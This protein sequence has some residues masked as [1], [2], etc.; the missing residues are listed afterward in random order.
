LHL[1][2]HVGSQPRPP[3]QTE[4]DVARYG[5][6]QPPPDEARASYL[7]NLVILANKADAEGHY[8]IAETLD[9][10]LDRNEKLVVVAAGQHQDMAAAIIYVI[11]AFADKVA[12]PLKLEYINT[13]LSKLR[14]LGLTPIL[15]KKKNPTA[16]ANA[17]VSLCKNMLAGL[18]EVE[19]TQVLEKVQQYASKI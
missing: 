19:I 6:K 17:I 5:L 9:R 7:H 14:W 18:T 12:P 16:G 1:E 3:T 2:I 11:N 4:I 15:I 8:K 10:L 13:I